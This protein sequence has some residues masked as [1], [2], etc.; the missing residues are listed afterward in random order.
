MPERGRGQL[1][2]SSVCDRFVR[3]F[4]DV[5]KGAGQSGASSVFLWRV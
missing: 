5:A 4:A 2:A 1:G 3:V